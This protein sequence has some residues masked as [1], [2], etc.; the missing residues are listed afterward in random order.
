M[1][2]TPISKSA[3]KTPDDDKTADITDASSGDDDKAIAAPVLVTVED[4]VEDDDSVDEEA[5]DEAALDS[6]VTEQVAVPEPVA[7]P[8]VVAPAPEPVVAPAPAAAVAPA[9][10]PKPK[11]KW[12]RTFF[13]W[14]VRLL[15]VGGIAA[16]AYFAWPTINERYIQPVETT[17]A[18]LSTVQDRL[19]TSDERATDLAAR[20]DAVEAGQLNVAERLDGLDVS[21]LDQTARLDAIDTLISDQTTRL[22]ALDELAATLGTDLGDTNAAASRQLGVTRATELM[23]R[24]RLF[25]YQANYGLAAADLTDARATLAALEIDDP[26]IAD[27]IDRLDRA[28][29]NLPAFPVAAA[30][31]VDIAWQSLLGPTPVGSGSATSTPGGATTDSSATSGSATGDAATDGSA[32]TPTTAGG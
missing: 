4:H 3:R 22:D 13:R 27:V 32:T 19:G 11:R 15:V 20:L 24:S 29:A 25:L 6:E 28:I 1:S 18:D 17:A 8:V 31:D 9:P 10:A 16:G 30:A 23:S 21:T 26:I 2:P 7:E 5:P 12:R 14:F